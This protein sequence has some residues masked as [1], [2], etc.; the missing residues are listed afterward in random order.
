MCL[1]IRK[2]SRLKPASFKAQTVNNSESNCYGTVVKEIQEPPQNTTSPVVVLTAFLKVLDPHL[3]FDFGQWKNVPQATYL[4]C[5]FQLGSDKL[6]ETQS[7]HTT[8]EIRDSSNNVLE[9]IALNS[10]GIA[11]SMN[12]YTAQ[13][14]V[15]LVSD[16]F[17]VDSVDE[18]GSWWMPFNPLD[19]ATFVVEFCFDAIADKTGV[20]VGQSAI[21]IAVAAAI[22]TAV[23]SGG[24]IG[25]ILGA[26]VAAVT[27]A[28]SG[29]AGISGVD[30]PTIAAQ[31]ANEWFGRGFVVT[32]REHVFPPPP[33]PPPP[34]YETTVL[35]MQG[36]GQFLLGDCNGDLAAVPTD[37]MASDMT[38]SL[39]TYYQ[40]TYIQN[41]ELVELAGDYPLV[42]PG[43]GDAILDTTR[44]TF[45][46]T[47]PSSRS[48]IYLQLA[49]FLSGC[50]SHVSRNRAAVAFFFCS[51]P[52]LC[53][54]PN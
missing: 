45:K 23:G 33:P 32:L 46:Y 26:V 18:A 28:V 52:S 21:D 5:R 7:A 54:R 30:I 11:Y 14:S 50:Q 8:V 6:T 16:Q 12:G 41:M 42:S 27:T 37:P 2:I 1:K 35:I 22:V 44:S 51:F 34:V 53:L 31:A 20:D 3:A 15:F 38:P 49:V 36:I 13:E 29:I 43:R 10:N 48:D 17:D 9:S 24:N 4:K 25:L 40:Y 47:R 19:Y 39:L